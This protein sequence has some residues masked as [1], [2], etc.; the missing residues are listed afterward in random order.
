MG[1]NNPHDSTDLR[2][3]FEQLL[4]DRFGTGPTL[5]SITPLAGDASS[6]RYFRLTLTGA[7]DA[8]ATLVAM[9]LGADVLPLSSEE[10]V[11]F[12]K[13]PTELPYVNVGR[14]LARIG[15]RIPALHHYD[16]ARGML[17]LEDIGNETLRAAAERGD[18]ARILELYRQ[19]IDQLAR[20]QVVGTRE[21]DASCVAFQQRFDQRL[22]AWEFEHFLEH[23]LPASLAGEHAR[24]RTAFA[25][26][27][28]RLAAAPATLAHRDFH[29]WNLHVVDGAL[30]VIDF[31]DALL[32][33]ATYDLASLLTDRDT[34]EVITPSREDDLI[35]YY[36]R[37]RNDLGGTGDD[38]A[39][40][41][42][43]YF[44]CVL[45]RALKVIGRFRY[46]A[47]VKGKPGHL[48]YLAHVSRQARRALAATREL[49]PLRAALEPHLAA[50]CAG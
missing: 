41:R 11:V 37:A 9:V 46:L 8:P 17:L 22:F 30:C 39:G 16:P 10:L 13:P 14:F 49:Q 24:L 50:A 12:E 32:A 38:L 5:D 18:E 45:Q 2:P 40:V 42:S 35:A 23:G 7:T 34:A 19:A 48:R 21:A 47:N 1:P 26:V 29:G 28:D 31:Q 36:V 27:V 44:L 43:E 4:V 6:R 15:V 33:P 20:L 3:A 25:P